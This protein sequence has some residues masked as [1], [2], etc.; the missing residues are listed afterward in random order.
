MPNKKPKKRDMNYINNKNLLA[1][2]RTYEETGER[3]EELGRMFL[4]LAN[5]TLIGVILLDIRG[6]MI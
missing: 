5:D 1:E 3:T 6:K 4:L 2:L